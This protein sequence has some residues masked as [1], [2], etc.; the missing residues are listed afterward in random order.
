MSGSWH[1]PRAGW[2]ECRVHSSQLQLAGNNEKG[3]MGGWAVG[4]SVEPRLVGPRTGQQERRVLERPA[5]SSAGAASGW[6]WRH[7]GSGG[8]SSEKGW[9]GGMT[10]E[11]RPVPGARVGRAAGVQGLGQG[12]MGRQ[13][14]GSQA[15]AQGWWGSRST[16]PGA[17]V[18]RA[19]GVQGL[20]WCMEP[21]PAGA[22]GQGW[23]GAGRDGRSVGSGLAVGAGAAGGWAWRGGQKWWHRL[24]LSTLISIGK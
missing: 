17:R 24:Y 5:A 2:Q 8:S 22:K 18:G 11:L 1:G 13:E 20:C 10:T 19:A 4:V 23:W 21:G 9:V 12:Q 6:A 3:Q 14:R 15:S 16:G 7:G